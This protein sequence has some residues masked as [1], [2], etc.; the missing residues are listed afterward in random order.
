MS[1]YEAIKKSI[2]QDC[3]GEL[4]ALREVV[5][6]ARILLN[7]N[8]DNE[9]DRSMLEILWDGRRDQLRAAVDHAESFI[10]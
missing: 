4:E 9:G 7:L 1:Y 2:Q 6:Q 5:K 8:A 10:K 3:P